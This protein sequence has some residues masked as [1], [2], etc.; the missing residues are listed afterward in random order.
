MN[1]S[2]EMNSWL[3]RFLK[4]KFLPMNFELT[5]LECFLPFSLDPLCCSLVCMGNQLLKTM[6]YSSSWSFLSTSRTNP[7]LCQ[8]SLNRK[9]LPLL[10]QEASYSSWNSSRD[11]SS[12][13]RLPHKSMLFATAQCLFETLSHVSLWGLSARTTFSHDCLSDG[14]C[15]CTDD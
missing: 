8:L 5:S 10:A 11:S 12:P 7:A 13:C 2:N 14:N 15:S 4:P 9:C 6:G 3:L 1:T